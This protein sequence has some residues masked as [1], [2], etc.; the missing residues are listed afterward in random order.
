MAT[1]NFGEVG[2]KQPLAVEP[3]PGG[4]PSSVIHALEAIHMKTVLHLCV[5]P[6][7]CNSSCWNRLVG[8]RVRSRE[9]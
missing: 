1:V 3:S 7:G 8:K 4:A 9:V 5:V 6:G 2:G